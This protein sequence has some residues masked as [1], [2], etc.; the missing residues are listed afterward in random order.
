MCSFQLKQSGLLEIPASA[1][2]FARR[3]RRSPPWIEQGKVAFH[4]V[5]IASD[6]G[7]VVEIGAGL[8]TGQ[9]VALNI[10]DQIADGDRV[11]ATRGEARGELHLPARP[12]RQEAVIANVSAD[13]SGR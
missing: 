2:C 9:D 8:S 11:A 3:V 6:Q 1:W 12:I 5:T 10:G 4:N 7:D 13:T